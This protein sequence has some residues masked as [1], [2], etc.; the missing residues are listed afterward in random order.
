MKIFKPLFYDKFRCIADKCDFTCCRDW[1]IS[2]DDATYDNWCTLKL[3]DDMAKCTDA[4]ST[5]SSLVEEHDEARRIVLDNGRCPCLDDCGLC[6]IVKQYG[7]ETLSH[8]CHIYPREKHVFNDRIEQ[9]LTLSCKSVIEK[10]WEN[11]SF[12]VISEENLNDI[13]DND[14]KDSGQEECPEYLIFLREWFIDIA[15]NKKY[16]IN[17]ALKIILYIAL[18]I[19]DKDIQLVE[20]LQD[21]KESGILDKL[22]EVVTDQ[23]KQ[24]DVLDR[25]IENNELLLDLF[26]RYYEQKKYLDHIGVIYEKA[27]E[28]EDE[29]D[30]GIAIKEYESYL[31]WVGERYED[32]LRILICEE[33][34]SSLLVS[35]FDIETLI[36]KIEWLAIELAVLR[37]WMFLYKS[38]NSKLELKDLVQIVS[39]LFRITGYCDDDIIEYLSD[40]FEEIIWD[41]GYI[42]LIL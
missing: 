13:D 34:W 4:N 3:P 38:V 17:D 2:V 21:Y 27:L 19:R 1:T 16:N 11:D 37:Q 32:K 42:D 18:D 8:T 30:D 28:Y 33:L 26:I 12:M 31:S 40:S 10:L 41:W 6:H 9:S 24:A 25:F 22:I 7:E 29:L 15:K 39:V 35:Y 5:L 14:K 20:E 36:V 23:T